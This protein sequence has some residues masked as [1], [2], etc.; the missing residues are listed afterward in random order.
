[1][2]DDI[3]TTDIARQGLTICTF[4]YCFIVRVARHL[5]GPDRARLLECFD[6]GT[7]IAPQLSTVLGLCGVD[8]VDE[9][10][11]AVAKTPARY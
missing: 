10:C 5:F 1:M 3:L 7:L 8:H 2:K 9:H 6:G 4:V 11:C